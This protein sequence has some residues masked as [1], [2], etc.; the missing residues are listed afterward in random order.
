MFKKLWGKIEYLRQDQQVFQAAI[1]KK[2]DAVIGVASDVTHNRN[3][4]RRIWA[5]ISDFFLLVL[6]VSIKKW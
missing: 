3:S 1:C 4:I 2:V 5:T 6:G